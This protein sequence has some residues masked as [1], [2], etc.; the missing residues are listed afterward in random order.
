[1]VLRTQRKSHGFRMIPSRWG[2]YS[3]AG[4]LLSV[5]T[6][7]QE[8]ILFGAVYDEERYKKGEPIVDTSTFVH[9][10]VVYLSIP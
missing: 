5:L 7:I 1:M 2:S 6:M 10:V 9:L 4:R 8:N 3:C